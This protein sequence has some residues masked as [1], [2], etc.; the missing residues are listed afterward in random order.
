MDVNRFQLDI[1]DLISNEERVYFALVHENWPN[2]TN[3]NRFHNKIFYDSQI[4]PLVVELMDMIRGMEEF[5]DPENLV[6]SGCPV[7]GNDL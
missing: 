4:E 7:C 2:C 1:M 3:T 5:R 6:L